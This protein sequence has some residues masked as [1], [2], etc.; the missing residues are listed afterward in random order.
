[1]NMTKIFFFILFFIGLS[2]PVF[3][4]SVATTG[5][6]EITI[7]SKKCQEG[8]SQLLA[9]DYKIGK[10]LH[11]S[12]NGIGAPDTGISFMKSDFYGDFYG[13]YGIGHS[14]IIVSSGNNNG[15]GKSYYDYAFISPKN[16][17]VYKDWTEC[18]S[19]Y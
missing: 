9:C 10:S 5:T 19:S 6:Y 2:L 11:I 4:S 3:S 13:T 14:C 1:M 18:K 17:K 7:K 8:A 15:K 16:G 12:I